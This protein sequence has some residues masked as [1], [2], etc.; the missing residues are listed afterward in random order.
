MDPLNSAI[1]AELDGQYRRAIG[2][3]TQLSKRGSVLDRVGVYQ[4][5]A[6]CLEK[7]GSLKKAAYWH[8]RAGEAYLK[9]PSKLMAAQER[10]YYAML[11]F[12]G[13]VQDWAPDASRRSAAD[14]YLK[15]FKM[16][17]SSGKEGYSH[18]MLFAAHLCAKL[19]HFKQAAEFFAETATQF[20]KEGQAALA[21]ESH[22][23]EAQY[24]ERSGDG[25]LVR[26][27]RAAKGAMC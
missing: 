1:E 24:Y 15:T 21:K 5:I 18:E 23:L 2:F 11:E 20:E 8:E 7:L 17:L 13:A 25:R 6:R 4:A 12:R 19:H 14:R 27:L 9:V 26:K 3:Y 16:C 10:A 22:L